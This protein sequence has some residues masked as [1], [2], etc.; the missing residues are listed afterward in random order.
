MGRYIFVRVMQ[1]IVVIFLIS[2]LTFIIM[3]MMPGDPVYLLFGEGKV[4]I[5]EE[6]MQAIRA[7]WGLDQP[8]YV[9]YMVWARNMLTGDF[10]DSLIRTGTP[11]RQMIF[12]AIPVTLTL[13][14]YA[15]LLALSISIPLGIWAGMRRNSF[16]DYFASIVSAMGI[17]TPNFWLGLMLIVIFSLVL[18]LLP[19]FGLRSWQGY[20]LPVIVLAAE[21]MAV[22][23][24]VMRSSTVEVLN[25]DYVRTARAKGLTERTVIIRHAVRNALLPVVTVI[26][27]N[28]AFIL[29]GTIVVETVFALPGIGRL[30]TDS[31]FRL[32]Y[33]VVQSLFV[34]LAALVVVVNLLTDLLYA[35]IDPRIRF[36]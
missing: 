26:G 7:R 27:F 19:P 15:M 14:V 1:G 25:E 34:L 28:I 10:G 32:D 9:Q 3:R 21:Q 31:V 22:V 2:V 17:A 18:G 30:F 23:T 33:Q 24:R 11:V 6:Q 5:T 16:V 29:S 35:L 20:I 8:Y 12:E 4:R 36:D 13:N